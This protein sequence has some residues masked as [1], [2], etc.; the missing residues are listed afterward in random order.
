MGAERK[1]GGGG[2]MKDEKYCQDGHISSRLF[3][4]F[5]LVVVVNELS[6]GG[7]FLLLVN[8]KWKKL[9]IL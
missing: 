1:G 5:L 2:A 8:Q 3:G 9:L 7:Q 6:R 4:G